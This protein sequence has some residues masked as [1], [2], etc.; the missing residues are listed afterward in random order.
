MKKCKNFLHLLSFF[1]LL[2]C[3]PSEAANFSSVDLQRLIKNHPT[4]K[5][6]QPD[7]GRFKNTPSEIQPISIVT[8]K[9]ASL[10]ARIKFLE[11]DKH[12]KISN[13]LIMTKGNEEPLWRDI[14]AIDSEIQFL[15]KEIKDLEDL[16]AAGGIPGFECVL[17]ISESLWKDVD[18]ELNQLPGI[19]LNKLPVYPPL[20]P[21]AI[22]NNDL[23]RF[24]YSPD[25]EQLINYTRFSVKTGFLFKATSETIVYQRGKR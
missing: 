7:T 15:K 24:F 2:I 13:H 16:A 11:G 3:I 18:S 9:I 17:R 14:K 19:V 12:E 8:E 25:H 4:M 10:S 5:N 20:N 6:Y 22:K 23:R 1:A 21:P